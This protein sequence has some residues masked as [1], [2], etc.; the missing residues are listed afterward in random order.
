MIRKSFEDGPETLVIKQ[1]GDDFQVYSP[2]APSETYF[3]S[4]TF[5][6]PR[7]T[8][9]DFA[10]HRHDPKWRCRHILAVLNQTY[11]LPSAIDDPPQSQDADKPA[12]HAERGAPEMAAFAESI[13]NTSHMVIKRSV[14]PDGRIDSLSVEF[15]VPLQDEEDNEVLE[16]ARSLITLQSGIV[17]QFLAANGRGANPN[18]GPS[19]N[20]S[21]RSGAPMLA[22]MVNVA[23]TP[24]KWGR[25]LFIA[26]QAN[27]K[28][29]RLYGDKKQL[30]Q[31]ITAAG[32]PELSESV[33][34][35]LSLQLPCRVVTKP[36]PD[37]KY[38][39]VEQVLP[40]QTAGRSGRST[41]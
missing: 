25:R 20:T 8:C 3:V 16:S 24:G 26:I 6:A 29:L 4:G 12:T 18:G 11:T 40:V 21:D 19:P 34:E 7:C 31:F 22:E 28:T 15:V 36:T 2:A 10:Q 32:F 13:Q 41:A 23:G 30:G 14:S 35:G 9:P 27:G 1:V 38:L 5:D 17:G 39:N 37:G 33:T